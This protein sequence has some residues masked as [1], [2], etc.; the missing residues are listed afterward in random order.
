MITITINTD[1]DAFQT[2]PGERGEVHRILEELSK[3]GVYNGEIIRDIN[4][5]TVGKVEIT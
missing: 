5:N 3:L 4:G 1:N 2:P